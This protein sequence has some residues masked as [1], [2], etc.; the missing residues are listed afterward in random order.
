LVNTDANAAV[1]AF[2]E[3]NLAQGKL[4]SQGS[5]LSYSE[6]E[7]VNL[8]SAA[9][10][11]LGQQATADVARVKQLATEVRSRRN[12]ARTAGDTAL[13]ERCNTQ[14]ATLGE[15][16]EGPDNLKLTQLV[17]RAVLRMASE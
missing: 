6:S 12:A 10:E 17:G 9:R 1:E 15:R 4:F 16:L 11:K 2:L 8:P 7:F 3:L 14:L 13:A 5:A